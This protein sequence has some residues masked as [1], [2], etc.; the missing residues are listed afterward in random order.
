MRAHVMIWHG[1]LDYTWAHVTSPGGLFEG[2][3]IN[4]IQL[5]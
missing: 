5:R 3:N 1:L 2:I 4:L